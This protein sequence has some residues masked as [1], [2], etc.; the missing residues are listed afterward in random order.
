MPCHAFAMPLP[1]LCHVGIADFRVVRSTPPAAGKANFAR[2]GMAKDP[3]C[4]HRHNRVASPNFPLHRRKALPTGGGAVCADTQISAL[5][6]KFLSI[7]RLLDLSRWA[8]GNV[9]RPLRR[10]PATGSGNQ[11]GCMQMVDA[12]T[13][14]KRRIVI[15]D[16]EY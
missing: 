9:R 8:M 14:Q 4:Q 1:C 11:P 12:E 5:P 2:T 10:P 15:E 7:H 13:T 3:G 6:E 16:Y